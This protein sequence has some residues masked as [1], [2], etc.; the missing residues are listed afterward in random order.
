MREKGSFGQDF[1]RAF[2][3][4]VG[5]ILQTSDSAGKRIKTHAFDERAGQSADFGESLHETRVNDDAVKAHSKSLLR[6]GVLLEYLTISLRNSLLIRFAV[7][8][9]A[10]KTINLK[11]RSCTYNTYTRTPAIC[12]PAARSP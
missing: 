3:Y 1:H 4:K 6:I 2:T 11:Q 5:F 8:F 10:R 7:E 9:V 12:R